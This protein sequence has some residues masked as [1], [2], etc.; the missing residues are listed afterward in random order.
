MITHVLIA[1]RGEI[2]S[3]VIR[4]C[5]RLG[6]GTVAV[7]SDADA[8]A[9]YVREAD[10][11]WPLA[12]D[13][14]ADTYLRGD[15]L[16]GAALARG[17]DAIHPGYGFLSEN[18]AFAQAVVDAGLTW[19]GPPS[20]AMAAMGSKIE[21]KRLMRASG[22]P[23]L[24][25][26]TVESLAE[27]GVPALVKASAGGGGRGMRIVR[28]ISTL[29]EAV[30]AAEREAASAFGDGTVFVERYVE[31]GRHIEI[32][33]FAD[34]RGNT[35]SLFERDCTVQ[36]RHQKIIEESPSPA[37][38]ESLRAAMSAAAVA[39]AKAVGYVGAG[40]VEFLV[41]VDGNFS[42]L[43]MNTRLQVEH[44]VTEMVTGLDL[45]E[46]QLAVAGGDALPDAALHPTIN[47]HAIEVR[48][49]T[50]DPYN[51]YLPS[52]G[53]F[54]RIDF[55]EIDGVRVDSGVASGS[56]VTPFYD[57]MIAKVIAHAPTRAGAIN[58]LERALGQAHLIGPITNR[59]QLL[60]LL[61]ELADRWQQID[62]GWLD[63]NPMGPPE[64]A[65]EYAAA[66]GLAWARSQRTSLTQIPAGWRNNPS[67]LQQVQVGA[68]DVRYRYDRAGEVLE[69]FVDGEAVT[70]D[71]LPALKFIE[72]E[73][74]GDVVFVSRG[75]YRFRMPPRYES[76]DDAGRAGSTVAPMP[77]SILR[78]VV[79]VGDVVE[80][81]QALLTMEA[82]KMEH[83]VV[84]PA[85]GMVAEV[86]VGAGQQVESGQPL[87]R[88]E[89]A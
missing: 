6:V 75:Q 28:D 45:V 82:M 48:L 13:A 53:T 49:C 54:R 5:R 9:P 73:I 59:S 30:A 10:S 56:E 43:E 37:V 51:G 62:T 50:E 19:I 23:V 69:A 46:L 61:P 40:T 60:A 44:P 70:A 77:G 15:L 33:V 11:S 22:V 31:G 89:S 58:K 38:D 64:I 84:S 66:A 41:D 16:I 83:Q 57:S 1:N 55:P 7:F 32:Q 4:T 14:P 29:D 74:H 12:G 52:S 67:Q 42:F 27:I 17:C 71:W 88:I 72:T 81:G 76:P 85:S 18:A 35:V 65:P 86:F 24:P 79:S 80:A 87:V 78:V 63:R 34:L 39:A 2:A 68:H 21:A 8:H 3:R 36:R 20:S 25:D 47:G 26:N